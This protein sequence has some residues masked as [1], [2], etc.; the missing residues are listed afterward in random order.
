MTLLDFPRRPRPMGSGV[1]R[2]GLWRVGL[3]R[4]RVPGGGAVLIDLAPGDGLEITD[5]EGAQPAAVIAFDARGA[6]AA[7]IGAVADTA[8]PALLAE[9]AAERLRAAAAARGLDCSRARAVALFGPDSPA[10]AAAAFTA[11]A[12]CAVIVAAPGAAMA[13]DAQTPP[14]EIRVAVTRAGGGEKL[15]RPA[16]PPLADPRLD[17]RVDPGRAIAYEVR[18]GDWIQILDVQGR[19]CS[20]FQ[21][22]ARRKVDAG[23]GREIDPTATRSMTGALYPAP[24]LGSKF[25]SQ[26]LEPLVEVVQDTCGRHDTFG[27]A[28]TARFYE[29]MGYPGHVNCS[30]NLNAEAAPWGLPARDGWPAVNFFYNTALDEA[31]RIGSDEPWSRPGDYVLMRAMTDLVCFSTACPSDIDATNGFD[32]TEIQ[33]RVY[34][35]AERFSRAVAWRKTPDAEPV[36]TA[37]TPFHPRTGALTRDFASYNGFWLPNVYPDHGAVAEYWACRERAAVMDLSALRKFEVIGPDA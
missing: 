29:D 24:G 25:F 7:L 17:V 10:R 20:D 23:R 16:P 37:E 14:T 28:C 27:L 11:T 1:R 8:A 26:D 6:D 12:R 18:K 35:G 9:P 21:A 31:F 22:F 32:P 30:E 3:E 19:E 15:R 2:P 4:H 5:P 34:D 36:M 33:I 13:P